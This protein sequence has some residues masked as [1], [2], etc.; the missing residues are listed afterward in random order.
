MYWQSGLLLLSLIS[1]AAAVPAL[2]QEAAP[3]VKADAAAPGGAIV[4]DF[5]GFWAHPYNPGLEP[6][7]SGPGPVRRVATRGRL[8]GDYTNPILKPQAAAAVKKHNDI[9]MSGE[10][11]PIP[12]NQCWPSGVPYI[13]FQSACRCCSSRARSIS[14]TSEITK[15]ATCA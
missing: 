9:E 5:S 14:S 8:I 1:A 2:G 4:P 6:P 15:C 13:F 10:A 3:V 11:A 12:S 7:A